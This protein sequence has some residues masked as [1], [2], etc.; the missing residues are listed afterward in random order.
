MLKWNYIGLFYNSMIRIKDSNNYNIW[1]IV[2][3]ITMR[4]VRL[5]FMKIIL[6][7]VSG[8]DY[9]FGVYAAVRSLKLR[10][11]CSLQCWS[12]YIC[13]QIYILSGSQYITRVTVFYVYTLK[14]S[15]KV[16]LHVKSVL[17][18][19]KK[20][21]SALSL[22]ANST[23]WTT[24]NCRRNLVPKFVDRWVSCGQS[25]RSP[26]VVNLSFLDRYLRDTKQTK[27]KL[28]GP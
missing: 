15:I 18:W 7:G 26:T 4:Q 17:A 20:T 10:H 25:G 8:C 9:K 14:A 3:I 28:R 19:Y 2:K 23:D 1:I 16:P 22:R 5:M 11:L 13:P 24:V 12:S 21:N 6:R 27:N